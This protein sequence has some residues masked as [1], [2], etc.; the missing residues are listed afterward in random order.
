VLG[1]NGTWTISKILDPDTLVDLGS[2]ATRIPQTSRVCE[3]TG[4]TFVPESGLS[5]QVRP[6]FI[7]DSTMQ[8]SLPD[9]ADI[10]GSVITARRNFGLFSDAN[11]DPVFAVVYSQVLSAQI[12]ADYGVEN[13]V[14]ETVPDLLF[15]YYPFY[16][17]DP[18]GFIRAYLRE[19]TAAGVIPDFQL[20]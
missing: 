7:A 9:A 4:A 1:N 14:A 15:R 18:L 2:W 20:L 8:S 6:V 5:W 17:A 12:L 10:T 13:A 3:V 11:F 19:I 16:L